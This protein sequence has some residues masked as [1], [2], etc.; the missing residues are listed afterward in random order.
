MW[1]W[2]FGD[3]TTAHAQ[4]PQHSYQ[5]DGIY[6]VTLTVTNSTGI[7]D[8]ITHN[9]T[10]L[11]APPIANFSVIPSHPTTQEIV[12]FNTSNSSDPDGSIVNW[13]WS[14]GDGTVGYEQ[15]PVH[16]YDAAGSYTVSLTVR[17]DDDA[18]ASVS[19][20]VN[21]SAPPEDWNPWDDD[22]VITLTEL[23]EAINHWVHDIPKNDHL[24]T[25]GEL[26]E[27]INMWLTG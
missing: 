1:N 25:L 26:Q 10:I 6:Q 27:F 22:G 2:S 4:H 3:G 7:T 16:V 13:I 14:F 15:H 11:N 23:Q 12:S 24:I 9:I 8:A 19:R 5:D 20:M 18:S 17:D 21:A